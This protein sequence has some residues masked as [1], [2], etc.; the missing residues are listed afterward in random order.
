MKELFSGAK[1]CS[2]VTNP[3]DQG[4]RSLGPVAWITWRSG[5]KQQKQQ[6][7]GDQLLGQNEKND[8]VMTENIF[9][10]TNSKRPPLGKWWVGVFDFRLPFG[11][12]AYFQGSLVSFRVGANVQKGPKDART[13]GAVPFGYFTVYWNVFTNPS[14]I[15]RSVSGRRRV[16]PALL[17][18]PT[19]SPPAEWF[20]RQSYWAQK[21][22]LYIATHFEV[23]LILYIAKKPKL[24]YIV[25]N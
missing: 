16:N 25:L 21:R 24:A 2:P 13:S 12:P 11:G 8:Q 9:P 23:N 17:D 1:G 22:G 7:K 19:I 18:C 5:R 3:T 20:N 10:E 15:H 6:E 14:W 4:D